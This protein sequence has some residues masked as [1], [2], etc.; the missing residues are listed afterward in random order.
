MY[1]ENPA[2]RSL[3]Q[4]VFLGLEL[5]HNFKMASHLI[6]RAH[7]KSVFAPLFH[8]IC[9]GNSFNPVRNRKKADKAFKSLV[10]MQHTFTCLRLSF[11]ADMKEEFRKVHDDDSV[12]PWQK[13]WLRII[14]D[15]IRFFIPVVCFCSSRCVE[16]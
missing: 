15:L 16:V 5:W 11:D 1:N 14:R 2:S 4:H 13:D 7:T 10:Q 8:H 9:P 12:K 3:R 6:Y